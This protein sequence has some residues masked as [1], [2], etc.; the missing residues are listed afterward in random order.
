MLFR[1]KLF[2]FAIKAIF[3]LIAI[4]LLWPFVAPAYNRLLIEVADKLSPSEI[5]LI[6]ENR[7]VLYHCGETGMGGVDS[8]WLHFG[9]ILVAALL[10]ATPGLKLWRRLKFIGIALVAVF[11]IH[12]VSLVA[13]AGQRFT[14][15]DFV[16][17]FLLPIGGSLFPASVWAA[18][19][20]KHLP[21][22]LSSTPKGVEIQKKRR[23]GKNEKYC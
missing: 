2:Q 16:A 1:N 9:L 17:I 23:E 5:S 19:C 20:L 3:V 14:G 12:V 11:A 8:S 10:I 6:D 21:E 4:Y 13:L 22:G 7:I 18:L 15:N